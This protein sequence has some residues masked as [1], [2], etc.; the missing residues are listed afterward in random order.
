MVTATD[1]SVKYERMMDFAERMCAQGY[2]ELTE[3]RKKRLWNEVKG[4]LELCIEN[5]ATGYEENPQ[6]RDWLP[7]DIFH[8][9]FA[10][11][12]M[13]DAE[14]WRYDEGKGKKESNR[15]YCHLSAICRSALDTLDGA[16]GVIGFKVG[17]IRRM[18]D[19]EIP[20]WFKAMYSHSEKLDKAKDH[21][22]IAL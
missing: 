9:H 7:C 5:E 18:Y 4:F 15:F 20:D 13:T 11:Y 10:E 17:D 6:D 22:L 1:M 14:Y 3:A 2:P 19:G 16:F 8:E 12:D 21:E